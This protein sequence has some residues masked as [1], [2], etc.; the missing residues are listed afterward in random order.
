MN[1]LDNLFISDE[2]LAQIEKRGFEI[3]FDQYENMC[4]SDDIVIQEFINVLGREEFY[5][6]LKFEFDVV[7]S[8]L[9]TQ[10]LSLLQDFFI[11][12][13]SVYYHRGFDCEFFFIS[14]EY[15]QESFFKNLYKA[16][17]NA[18]SAVYENL[19]KMHEDMAQ[20]AKTMPYI[21]VDPRYEKLIDELSLYLLHGQEKQGYALVQKHLD[22]FE[23]IYQFIDLVISPIMKRVGILWQTAQISVA[24]EHLATATA[25]AVVQKFIKKHKNQAKDLAVVTAVSSELHTFGVTLVADFL[26]QLGFDVIDLGLENSPQDIVKQ[27]QSVQPDLV[28]LSIT[29]QS[30]I[31]AMQNTVRLLKENKLFHGKV[32][33]GGQ[34]LYE[35]QKV[36]IQGADFQSRSLQELKEYL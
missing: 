24:K 14:F 32:I 26:K 25:N 19:K 5:E 29:L 35:P 17:A 11:W 16:H 12:K 18:L 22:N 15:W 28:V 2:G 30:N 4:K 6:S 10:N 27:V 21:S 34:G 36:A 13:Y 9:Y 23:D 1:R 31:A 3:V 20:K 8:L 7:Y 33:V